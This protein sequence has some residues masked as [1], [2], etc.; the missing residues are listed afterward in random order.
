MAKKNYKEEPW[1]NALTEE[2][3]KAIESQM[4]DG[5]SEESQ[6]EKKKFK[7]HKLF[8]YG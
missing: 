5:E 3:K 1:W 8:G 4:E 6:P 7:Y 2:E